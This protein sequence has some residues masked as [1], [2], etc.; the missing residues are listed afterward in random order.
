MSRFNHLVSHIHNSTLRSENTLHVVGV[1][2][3]PM[4]YHSRVRL[5]REWL[6]EMHATPHVKPYVVELGFG[7][8]HFEVTEDENPDH[9]RLYADQEIWHKESLIN[10]A[11][12]YLLPRNWK[13]LSWCDAD[14]FWPDKSWAKETIHQL[15]HYPVIQ[16]WR[17]CLDLGFNGQVL[18]HF[19]SF[20][21]IDQLGIPKQLH[22]SQ[23]YKYAHSGFAWA[24]RRSFWEAIGGLM[25]F[26]ILGSAD[27][28]MAFGMIDRVQDSVHG[29]MHDN[30]KKMCRE[31]AHLAYRACQGH[32]GYVNTRIEHRFHGPKKRRQYRERWQIFIDH[33]FDP[34]RDLTWDKQ[35]LV[36]LIG[37]PELLR[38]CRKYL[39]QRHEDSIEEY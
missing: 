20:C 31:W 14:V 1:L 7:D 26:P 38:D 19:Q 13:Y 32:L 17:D 27:H 15:Q 12:R 22:P 37:K 10:L 3:N 18:Q 34:I 21:F 16:P 28:H 23:P 2:F 5:F 25:D 11:V 4:R 8:R 35:G 29:K 24:C 30:F 39:S 9:L 33:G 36:R 6:K